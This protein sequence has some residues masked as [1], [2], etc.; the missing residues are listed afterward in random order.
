MAIPAS[1]TIDLR[2]DRE[3]AAAG[4][5]FDE[6]LRMLWGVHCVVGSC[7]DVLTLWRER[8]RDVTGRPLPCGHHMAEEAA[9]LVLEEALDLF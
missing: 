5:Q 8:V 9:T 1:A 2:H 7:F 3:D 6:P 4:R